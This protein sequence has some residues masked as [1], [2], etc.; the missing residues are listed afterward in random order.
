MAVNIKELLASALLDLCEKEKLESVTIQKL[1]SRTGVSR[2]TFYNHFRDKNDL[3]QYI[4]LTKIIPEYQ[5]S[6]DMPD[7]YSSLLNAFRR[8][9]QYHAFMKQ[10]CM[11]DDQ[12]CLKEYIYD[13]C[14]SFD[15]AWHQ[16][17]YGNQQMPDSLRFATEY[18]A[19]AS[20]SMTLS[21]ILSDMPVSCEEMAD[22]ITRLRGLGMEQLF[23]GS[24]CQG[25]PYKIP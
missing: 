11:M 18:H 12:N 2:Q 15:L 16:T 3:I 10:A 6:E 4:Y 24:C 14:K 1:L 25:N 19:A 20:T 8:M 7:F 23:E 17:L 9:K 5:D 13:H 21:W 22:F